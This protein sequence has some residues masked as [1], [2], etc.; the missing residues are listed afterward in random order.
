VREP[1]SECG[2]PVADK[3]RRHDNQPADLNDRHQRHGREVQEQ[4]G[5]ADPVEEPRADGY[6]PKLCR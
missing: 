4:P 6:E 1:G 2:R 5:K 3:A